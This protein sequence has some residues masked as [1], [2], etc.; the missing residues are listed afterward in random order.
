MWDDGTAWWHKY[1][2]PY[3]RL[4]IQEFANGIIKRM[5]TEPGCRLIASTHTLHPSCFGQW[6]LINPLRPSPQRLA[7]HKKLM[8][9]FGQFWHRFARAHAN[10]PERKPGQ[11]PISLT[12]VDDP[13]AK[14]HRPDHLSLPH[15]HATTLIRPCFINSL[16]YHVD[17]PS[18][19]IREAISHYW[20]RSG[21]AA[22]IHI[23]ELT[24]RLHELSGWIAYSAKYAW[25]LRRLHTD[26]QEWR[27]DSHPFSTVADHRA[28]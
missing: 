13:V 18:L 20:Y 10:H 21:G 3:E 2:L 15:I 6:S 5:L 24:H 1:Y 27:S 9:S 23:Q 16:G 4:E 7:A 25:L 12:F 19:V 26:D 17:S 22:D 11:R 14:L 28:L 8:C